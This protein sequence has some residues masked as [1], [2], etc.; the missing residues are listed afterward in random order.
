[1]SRKGQPNGRCQ[2]CRNPRAW[3][4]ESLLARG[5]SLRDV[6]SQFNVDHSIV[7]RHWKFHVS[8]ARRAELGRIV[9]TMGDDDTPSLRYLER[10]R[11]LVMRQ[12][13][14]LEESKT[15]NLQGLSS[16]L[17]RARELQLDIARLKGED[18]A[19]AAGRVINGMP[20]DAEFERRVLEAV[21]DDPAACAKLAR[22]LRTGEPLVSR[23]ALEVIA[24]A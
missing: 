13:A 6:A 16:L 10:M 8:E 18:G 5:A 4:I 9:E 23:P 7:G 14:A 21:A 15:K 11:D 17:G 12:L 22:A 3:F 2:I 20:A 1:M 24:D 19:P